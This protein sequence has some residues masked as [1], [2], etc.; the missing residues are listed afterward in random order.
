MEKL[1][2]KIAVEKLYRLFGIGTLLICGGGT[3][4]W[5]FLQQGVVDEL[6]LVIAPCIYADVGINFWQSV[7]RG[8]R[9]PNISRSKRQR[10]ESM[11]LVK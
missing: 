6:S 4:N 11:K 10:Q 7:S 5:T 9:C 2:S 3:V 1:D 8:R